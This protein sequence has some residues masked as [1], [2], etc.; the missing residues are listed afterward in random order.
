MGVFVD[1]SLHWIMTPKLD[2][3]QPCLIVAFNLSLEIFN[4]VPLPDE[5]KGEQ[6]N[7]EGDSFKIA[8]AVLGGCLC[9]TMNY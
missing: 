2:G 8:V 5:I 1:N 9:L 7:S 4:E 6:V 3:L